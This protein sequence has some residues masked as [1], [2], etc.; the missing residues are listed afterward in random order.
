MKRMR[1]FLFTLLIGAGGLALMAGCSGKPENSPVIRKKFAEVE[2][3]KETVEQLTA[4]MR[5]LNDE[6]VRIKEENSELRAFLPSVDGT[7][8][9][10]KISTLE[11]RIK[12]L[13]E[14]A[15]ERPST[16]SSG[17]GRS[18]ESETPRRT[19]QRQQPARSESS[20]R[21]VALEERDLAG[22]QRVVAAQQS[23]NEARQPS[24]SFREMTNRPRSSEQ[25]SAP[26]ATPAPSRPQQAAESSPAPSRTRGTYHTIS[27][28]ETIES[29]AQAHNLT[30]ERLRQAIGLPQGAR[31]RPGQ[32]IYI[33]AN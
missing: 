33:P 7:S 12:D 16:S 28:G 15:A 18:A 8:A 6:L 4:D 13:Q 19:E 9:I 32:R 29:I 22:S 27:Q 17:E 23:A 11:N 5:I 1:P 14:S 20:D 31:L 30:P 3:M 2:A 25:S 26:A 24:Q 10:E 21:E